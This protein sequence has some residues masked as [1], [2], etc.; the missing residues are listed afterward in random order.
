MLLLILCYY[1][2]HFCR[3]VCF[4]H[5]RSASNGIYN[6]SLQHWWKPDSVLI[7]SDETNCIIKIHQNNFEFVSEIFPNKFLG[8]SI[9]KSS[10]FVNMNLGPIY[11]IILYYIDILYCT[12][13]CFEDAFEQNISNS[14][15]FIN[16]HPTP[17][18]QIAIILHVYRFLYLHCIS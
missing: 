5:I 16:L 3:F 14:K 7:N 9:Y 2:H 12:C 1:G 8:T 10:D 17:L 6:G 11:L 18:F 13:E 4:M 15:T